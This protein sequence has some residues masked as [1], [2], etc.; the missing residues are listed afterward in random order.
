MNR[1]E[2]EQVSLPFFGIPKLLPYIKKYRKTIL[3]MVTLGLL[4][5]IF[6]AG[7]PLYCRY[8]LDHFVAEKT[9]DGLTFFILFFIAALL[10]YIV[11]N[12]FT[13]Y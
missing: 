2:E 10:A 8:A 12:F 1:N 11:L 4:S 5:C 13:I 6:D 3:L 9:L 7:L